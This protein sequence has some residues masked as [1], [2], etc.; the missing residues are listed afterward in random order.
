MVEVGI[1]PEDY[2][3]F[4]AKDFPDCLSLVEEKVKPERMNNNR[5]ERRER[6]WQYAEKCP[7]F[8]GLSGFERVLVCSRVSAHHFMAFVPNN[9][10]FAD[11]LIVLA[12]Q[13]WE[14]FACLSSS[15]HDAWAH[16]PG[17][18]THETRNTVLQ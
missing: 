9:Q 18:T 12:V 11:R 5:K 1:R 4:V 8:T 2:E 10:V 17:A 14:E 13:T 3:G 16:R 6:W 7:A 15:L